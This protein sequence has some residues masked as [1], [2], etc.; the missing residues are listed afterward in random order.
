MRVDLVHVFSKLATWLGLNFLDLLESSA[1]HE[2]SFSLKVEGKHLSK[3]SA[4]V[5]E[6][7]VGSKLEKRL[8]GWEMSAHL[9]NVFKSL[10]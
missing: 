4:H 10:L 5:G 3:L 2:C 6:N 9:D 8:K 1:L 7:V